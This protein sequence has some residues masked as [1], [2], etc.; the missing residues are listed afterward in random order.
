MGLF[1]PYVEKLAQKSDVKGLAKALLHEKDVN[2]CCAD[3]K[4][5]YIS[6]FNHGKLSLLFN[7][8][9]QI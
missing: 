4:F 2:L 3:V 7:Q 8:A 9:L 5:K 6:F 1:K